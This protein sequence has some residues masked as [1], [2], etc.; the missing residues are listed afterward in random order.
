MAD[1][2]EEKGSGAW[3]R[4]PV[5]DGSPATWKSFKREMTWWVSRALSATIWQ[6]GGQFE[7]G[8]VLG[9]FRALT[10]TCTGIGLATKSALCLAQGWVENFLNYCE[11]EGKTSAAG[12][13]FER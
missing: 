3:A 10:T 12:R 4:V 7:A 6:R 11:T 5:W 13:S 1:Y 9:S 2:G 8:K